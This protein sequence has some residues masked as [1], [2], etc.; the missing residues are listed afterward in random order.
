MDS[1]HK[2]A[3]RQSGC[4]MAGKEK[5]VL[6]NRFKSPLGHVEEANFRATPEAVEKAV[7]SG[8]TAL[9]F[10]PIMLASDAKT[11]LFYE[12]L[13]RLIDDSYRV[14]PARDFI[15]EVER[16]ETGR[17]IDL[18]MLKRGL[19]TLA[20]TPGLHLSLNVSAR[21]IGY[22]PWTHKLHATLRKQPDL[23]KRLTIEISEQSA[24]QLP[25]I[26]QRFVNDMRAKG[27]R[28]LLDEFGA[29]VSSF[30]HL[31]GL[32]VDMLK[33]DGRIVRGLTTS[34]SNRAIIASMIALAHNLG[35]RV[36]ATQVET[37]EQLKWLQQA[38]VDAVQGYLLG[39]P[40][41]NPTWQSSVADSG[42]KDTPP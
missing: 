21:S 4:V 27:L 22:A 34:Q 32:D 39:M 8:R 29:D 25:E 28:F 20:K 23:A 24:M 15:Y 6:E 35:K 7:N 18:E 26:T 17:R 11:P 36:I 33:I 10:Q 19:R 41:L 5:F 9:A 16:T 3:P 2:V 14:I 40:T 12:G 31:A 38:G 1:G 30:Q 37:G 42:G 13:I